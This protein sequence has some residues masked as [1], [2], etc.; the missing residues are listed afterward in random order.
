MGRRCKPVNELGQWS[1]LRRTLQL[2]SLY[3][4]MCDAQLKLPEKSLMGLWGI[5]K[6]GLLPTCVVFLIRSGADLFS[7]GAW[8]IMIGV[9][10]FGCFISGATTNDVN[11]FEAL[12]MPSRKWL[13]IARWLRAAPRLAWYGAW[14]AWLIYFILAE[15]QT[16][17]ALLGNAP[18][19]VNAF[20]MPFALFA[21][22][23]AGAFSIGQI[24][25]SDEE[26]IVKSLVCGGAAILILYALKIFFSAEVGFNIFNTYTNI[27]WTQQF[28]SSLDFPASLALFTIAMLPLQ[29]YQFKYR[30]KYSEGYEW[31]ANRT[32]KAPSRRF[33]VFYSRQGALS[34]RQKSQSNL[35]R[36][37]WFAQIKSP[38]L[39]AL[40]VNYLATLRMTW[41]RAR[42]AR[43]ILIRPFKL[44]LLP[45]SI[46]I[47]GRPFSIVAVFFALLALIPD[48]ASQTYWL[49]L[50][51]V[52]L[53]AGSPL[54]LTHVVQLH[55]YG[56]SY[57]RQLFFNFKLFIL[58]S[59]LPLLAMTYMPRFA[60]KTLY[61]VVVL[62]GL[63]LLR[64]GWTKIS[65][66]Q[67]T[68]RRRLF[69]G[70]TALLVSLLL[71]LKDIGA[72]IPYWWYWILVLIGALCL[73]RRLAYWT[74]ERLR[75]FA[76]RHNDYQMDRLL[77]F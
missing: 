9:L 32:Q 70:F 58:T 18:L 1:L 53:Y 28:S 6:W 14:L 21:F 34:A 12:R 3:G 16:S 27:E 22:G 68:M 31:D 39:R 64:G 8:W 77:R 72:H 19:F 36:P 10:F 11:V 24:R 44:A 17:L 2:D 60:I 30:E 55:L 23:A 50:L 26:L 75:N 73:W 61:R 4:R 42:Y 33:N 56:A 15:R 65:N 49:L 7:K 20:L 29:I 41:I 46:I 40:I 52:L 25:W 54:S 48:F 66:L 76:A 63:L 13:I 47:R 51:L 71:L 37:A 38:L 35:S 57:R 74:E 5:F 43:P 69:F 59:V 45:V 62:L 67:H